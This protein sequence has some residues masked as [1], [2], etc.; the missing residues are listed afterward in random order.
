MIKAF[1]WLFGLRFIDRKIINSLDNKGSCWILMDFYCSVTMLREIFSEFS[2]KIIPHGGP[3]VNWLKVF[4]KFAS[5][6]DVL[7]GTILSR[8]TGHG[9]GVIILD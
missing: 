7:K 9:I 6:S 1:I 3:D 2:L 5:G 4:T 8:L